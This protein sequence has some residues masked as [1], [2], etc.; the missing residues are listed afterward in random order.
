MKKSKAL[1]LIMAY[2]FISLIFPGWALGQQPTDVQMPTSGPAIEETYLN[3]VTTTD[4]DGTKYKLVVIGDVLP[5]LYVNGKTIKA[6]GL[7]NYSHVIE[8]LT[9]VLWK[10][11]KEEADKRN[12]RFGKT[13]DAIAGELV[14]AGLVKNLSGIVS[15]LL[16]SKKFII[17]DK[18][19]SM[20]VFTKFK[21]D[22]ITSTDQVFYFN[23]TIK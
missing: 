7:K 9:F 16:S 13:R 15:F 6:D 18:D 2:T 21:N 23:K 22:F 5:K 8:K 3:T 17:N 12:E 14:K 1:S 20:D 19:Q 4:T 11:Q 10:R